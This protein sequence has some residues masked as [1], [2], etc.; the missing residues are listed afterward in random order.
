VA[1]GTTGN[2]TPVGL[3]SCTGSPWQR[4]LLKDTHDL[5]S[6]LADK[7]VDVTNGGT[8]NGTSLQLWDC[9]GGVNQKWHLG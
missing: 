5:V 8:A 4:F 2:G 7:C 9:N 6:L 1:G 3:A